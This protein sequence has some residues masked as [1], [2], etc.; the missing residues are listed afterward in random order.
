MKSRRIIFG[1]IFSALLTVSLSAAGFADSRM[2]PPDNPLLEAVK[3]NDLPAVRAALKAGGAYEINQRGITG[4]LPLVRA[5]RNGNLEIVQLLA[6]HGATID[7][8]K[9]R[10][11]RTPLI[12]AAAQGHVDV[13]KFLLEKGADVNAR[14]SGL[15]P[16]LAASVW[17]NL[18][19]GPPGDKT[20]TIQALLENGADVNV[21]D[22]SW[23]KTGRTPLMYAVLRGDAA[24]VQALLAKGARKDLKNKD[25]DTA[26]SLARKKGLE[27]IA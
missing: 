24:V 7:I 26:L 20:K 18:P 4:D 13:V 16:L 12:E 27:Y 1:F 25:G 22:E 10:G 11:E 21:Q 6:E 19:A 8:G 5:A 2:P 15:T 23:L 3:K 14:G 17:G 9:D